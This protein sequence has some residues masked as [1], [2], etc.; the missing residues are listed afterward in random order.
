MHKVLSLKPKTEVPIVY[1]ARTKE[2]RIRLTPKKMDLL[3]E[4]ARQYKM[5]PVDL[6]NE[7]LECWLMD[8]TEKSRHARELAVALAREVRESAAYG[9]ALRDAEPIL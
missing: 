2:I 8:R 7:I 5:R 4:I 1:Q 6:A 9:S 3:E